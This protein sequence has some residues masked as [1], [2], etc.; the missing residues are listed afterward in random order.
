MNSITCFI[1]RLPGLAILV[2]E[3]P[4]LDTASLRRETLFDTEKRSPT[5]N[6]WPESG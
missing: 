5:S 3:G 4:L 1:L 2:E 6:G